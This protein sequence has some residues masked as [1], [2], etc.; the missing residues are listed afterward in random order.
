MWL[1]LFIVFI[2]QLAQTGSKNAYKDSLIDVVF[3][4]NPL[5]WQIFLINTFLYRNIR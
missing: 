3:T 5:V 4:R 1:K 2:L